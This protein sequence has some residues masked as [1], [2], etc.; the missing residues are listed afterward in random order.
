MKQSRWQHD[1]M[2][3]GIKAIS[4]VLTVGAFAGCWYGYYGKEIVSPFFALKFSKS[5]SLYSK[6]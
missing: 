4:V 3:R 5:P 1:L 2:L 6:S